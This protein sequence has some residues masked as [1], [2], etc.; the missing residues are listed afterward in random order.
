MAKPLDCTGARIQTSLRSNPTEHYFTNITLS[1]VNKGSNNDARTGPG[2][3]NFHESIGNGA[4]ELSETMK[5]VVTSAYLLEPWIALRA[6]SN[7][8]GPDI[9]LIL[10]WWLLAVRCSRKHVL[11]IRPSC[12]L[13]SLPKSVQPGALLRRKRGMPTSGQR[14]KDPLLLRDNS[15]VDH[16]DA[17]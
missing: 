16:G 11:Y 10:K 14:R 12:P 13:R 15:L 17:P 2:I 5:K 4:R 1:A 7:A 8:E 9:S 6:R 3:R